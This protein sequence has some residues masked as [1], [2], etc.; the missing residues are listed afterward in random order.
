M[1][2]NDEYK[3]GT[4]VRLKKPHPSGTTEWEVIRLGADIKIK[5]TIKKDLFI[6]MERKDFNRKV[7]SIVN[8]EVLIYDGYVNDSFL[9]TIDGKKYQKRVPKIKVANWENEEKVYEKMGIPVEFKENGVFIKEWIEG[10]TVETWNEEKLISLQNE[11]RNMHS[12]SHVDIIEHDWL[13]VSEFKNRIPEILW[14]DFLN[15]VSEIKKHTKVLSHNDINKNNVIWDGKK[16][17]LIDFE[18]ARA[19]S[20]YFDYAQFEVAEGTNIM[21]I[22]LDIN[23]YKDV[24]KAIIIFNYLWTFSLKDSEK[25]IRLRNEY[26]KMLSI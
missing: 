9:I 5:S 1:L 7:K 18:W 11:I 4:I 21:P 24:K 20:V 13:I 15:K 3:L 8:N 14:D 10:H 17:T 22:N 23:I 25:I 26:E 19:N 16:I 6:M 12:K 2:S